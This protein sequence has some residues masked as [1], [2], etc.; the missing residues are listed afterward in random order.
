ML[1]L[2][3]FMPLVA[4]CA[5]RAAAGMLAAVA[6]A[7]SG[8]DSLTIFDSTTHTAWRPRDRGEAIALAWRLIGAGHPVDLGLMQIVSSN[9][10]RL[11]LSLSCA[12]LHAARTILVSD[13]LGP[14]GWR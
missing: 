11:H 7:E 13:V 8:F 4:A 14:C 6:G 9:L 3:L 10:A 5:P 12:S 2:A 1:P